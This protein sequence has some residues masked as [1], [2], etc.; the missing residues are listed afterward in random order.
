MW[1]ALR[2]VLRHRRRLGKIGCGRVGRPEGIL[3]FARFDFVGRKKIGEEEIRT[4]RAGG[5]DKGQIRTVHF[6]PE[7]AG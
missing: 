5:T 4:E 6:H 2:G 3:R 1:W 7:V